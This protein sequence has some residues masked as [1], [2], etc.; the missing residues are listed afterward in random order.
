MT[1]I[2]SLFGDKKT[3]LTAIENHQTIVEM[4]GYPSNKCGLIDGNKLQIGKK[5]GQGANGSAFDVVINRKGVDQTY[6]V[7]KGT[8]KM[9]KVDASKAQIREYMKK[10]NIK[11]DIFMYFQPVDF[12]KKYEDASDNDEFYG[13]NTPPKKC[14]NSPLV[15]D[16]NTYVCADESFSELAIGLYMGNLSSENKCANFFDVYTMFTCKDQNTNINGQS[17]FTKYTFMQKISGTLGDYSTCIAR[18]PYADLSQ[19]EHSAAMNSFYIQTIFAIASYQEILGISHNDLHQENVFVEEVSDKT[20]FMGVKLQDAD[21]YQ[22]NVTREGKTYKI[23]FPAIPLLVKIGDFGLANKYKDP[24]IISEQVIEHGYNPAKA[25]FNWMIPI[26]YCKY[27]DTQY[28]TACLINELNLLKNPPSRFIT[29]CVNDCFGVNYSQHDDI[30]SGLL[31]SN[32]ITSDPNSYRR[33]FISNIRSNATD[34]PRAMTAIEL[35]IGPIYN[36]FNV[37]PPAGSK[38]VIIGDIDV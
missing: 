24:M 7:K 27:Y 11:K 5:Q 14:L 10:E 19:P 22:Y 21:Y 30:L 32:L 13:V 34:N 3:I 36:E 33:P 38:I 18:Q 8:L 20:E 26:Y 29:K 17:T 4:L 12:A 16:Q 1:T 28:F 25:T 15:T 9:D 37:K 23:Y 31:A 6:V 35:V 2:E